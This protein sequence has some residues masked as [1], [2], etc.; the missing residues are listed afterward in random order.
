MSRRLAVAHANAET[1]QA[2]RLSHSRTDRLDPKMDLKRPALTRGDP[3]QP[4]KRLGVRFSPHLAL[5]L[6][7]R[8]VITSDMAKFNVLIVVGTRMGMTV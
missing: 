3:L 4:K 2:K 6:G 8:V 7:K 1:F 5:T